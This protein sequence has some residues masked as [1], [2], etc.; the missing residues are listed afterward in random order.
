LI[1][2]RAL[3]HRLT[4]TASAAVGRVLLLSALTAALVV[5]C[6]APSA[7]S[8][9]AAAQSAPSA[10]ASPSADADASPAATPEVTH[11]ADIAQQDPKPVRVT[12]I[13]LNDLHGNIEERTATLP[14]SPTPLPVQLGGAPIMAS[15]FEIARRDNPRTLILD[16]GDAY[17]G[18]LLSNTF[19]GLPVAEAYNA[20]GVDASTF[21]NHEFDYGDRNDQPADAT[22][23]P[24]G[25]MKRLLGVAKFSYLSANVASASDPHHKLQGFPGVK[26]SAIFDLQ[27]VKVGVIGATTE[28]T[29]KEAAPANLDGLLFRSTPEVITEEARKLREQGALL[30]VVLIHAGGRCDMK[31]PPTRGD[32][33]CKA[34]RPDEVTAL[35]DAIPPGTVDAVLAGHI[36]TPQA[37][38]IR[39]VPVLQTFGFGGSFSRLDLWVNL[40]ASPQS[41]A[42]ERVTQVEVAR[43]TYF[44]HTHFTHYPSCS[45][46]EVKVGAGYPADLG[47][48]TPA[49][50]LGQPVTPSPTVAAVLAPYQAQTK[51]LIEEHVTDLPHDLS[52]DRTAE[53]P[54][55][56]C[57]ADA[58][59]DQVAHELHIDADLFLSHSGGIR[60]LLPQHVRFGDVFNVLPFDGAIA[61]LKLTGD[62]LNRFGTYQSETPK[63]VSVLSDRGWRIRLTRAATF[64]RFRGFLTPDG[65]PPKPDAYYTILT[66]EFNVLPGGG[67]DALFRAARAEGRI[68]LL[69]RLTRDLFADRL[70]RAPLPP[71]CLNAPLN[72]TLLIDE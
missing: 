61:V 60:A 10:Q 59:H 55:S 36:H 64:P 17:Q 24:Q 30:V 23:D 3:R 20:L 65:T 33:A 66:D 14:L 25:A 43:P 6:R 31:L 26:P 4:S 22:F 32:E 9:D 45:P 56:N 62:E 18:T 12:L 19:E 2:S 35:L 63:S 51:A 42:S 49:T 72:R 68:T 69:P 28:S 5:G 44:C 53:S 70:S 15:Y 48:P 58:I 29:P 27:G 40:A 7:P 41:P 39:G 1:S 34:D 13:G 57:V 8:P 46:D 52:H 71:S 16:A 37:H 38:I 54:V 50:Y 11:P 67:T 47:A 21:G